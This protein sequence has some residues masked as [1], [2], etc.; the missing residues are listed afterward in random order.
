MECFPSSYELARAV[1]VYSRDA[2]LHLEQ[3]ALKQG[4]EAKKNTKRKTLRIVPKLCFFGPLQQKKR[5]A[6]YI[7]HIFV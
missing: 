5:R 7:D 4:Y 2:A 1:F 6:I 3:D